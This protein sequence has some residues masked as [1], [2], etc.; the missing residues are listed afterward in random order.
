MNEYGLCDSCR[1]FLADGEYESGTCRRYAPRPSDHK[2]SAEWPIVNA[3]DS[4]GEFTPIN[5]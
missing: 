2:L 5:H 3:F 1:Y 4:C